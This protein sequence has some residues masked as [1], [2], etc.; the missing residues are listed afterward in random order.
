MKA[1]ET[2]CPQGKAIADLIPAEA[3][4]RMQRGKAIDESGGPVHSGQTFM[5]S[6]NS[7][8]LGGIRGTDSKR[9]AH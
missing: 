2:T 8:P 5:Y 7:S 6:G 1:G 9:I 4:A 3:Q